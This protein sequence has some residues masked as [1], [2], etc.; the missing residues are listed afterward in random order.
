[1]KKINAMKS[2]LY[3]IETVIDLINDGQLLALAGDEK[4]LRNLPKSII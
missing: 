4:V 2:K 3:K 1:M